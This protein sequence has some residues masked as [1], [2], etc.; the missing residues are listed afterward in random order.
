[1]FF[2]KHMFDKKQIKNRYKTKLPDPRQAQEPQNAQGAQVAARL[3]AVGHATTREPR[4]GSLGKKVWARLGYVG[5]SFG[6]LCFF[7]PPSFSPLCFSLIF[8]IHGCPVSLFSRIFV[9]MVFVR[10]RC[11]S[12]IC[13]IVF[14]CF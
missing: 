9:I 7:F 10:R 14:P 11:F 8:S 12:L 2:S 3:Q 5:F 13:F 6:F 4:L 1:M